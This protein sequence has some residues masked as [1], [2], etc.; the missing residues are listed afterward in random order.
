MEER[1]KFVQD[2]KSDECEFGR[3]MPALRRE[4]EDRVQVAGAI[5]SETN[6]GRRPTIPMKR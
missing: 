5:P 1:S 6:R 4:P 3:A 2:Y